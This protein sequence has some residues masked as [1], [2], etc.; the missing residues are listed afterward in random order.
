LGSQAETVTGEKHTTEYSKEAVAESRGWLR[1]KQT[2][3][4]LRA[5][6]IR[7]WLRGKQTRGWLRGK[8]S[9]AH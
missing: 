5:T 3:G 8:Q 6:H 9:H 7:G 1:G 4:W 2:R